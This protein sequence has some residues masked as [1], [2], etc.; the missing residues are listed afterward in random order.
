MPLQKDFIWGV[1]TA[2]YQVEGAWNE[3]G[4]GPSIWDTCTHARQSPVAHHDTG[5][6]ACDH[7]HRMKEDVALLA[8]LGVKAYRFSIAWTRILPE[9]TG[10]VNAKGLQFYSDLVDELLKYGIEPMITIYHWDMPQGI[11]NRGGWLNPE[12][13]GWFEN[14]TR[15][16][17][18]ALSDRV[19]YWFTINEPQIF[20][21]LG[22]Y[23][24][25]H[26]PFLKMTDK[27]ILQMT[28][29]VLLSHGTAVRT[30]RK[31]SKKPSKV[32]F[33]PTVPSFIPDDDSEEAIEDARKN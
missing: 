13:I 19:T 28:R 10:E 18:E 16:L 15:I 25:A 31:Y 5:D 3:D 7:Y 4:K 29:N 9:G 22:Y 33:A 24:G 30:I 11:Y 14:Y 8:K 21:G 23:M 26:A 6:I 17:V 2:S 32:S 1:A 12:I 27:D 20:I